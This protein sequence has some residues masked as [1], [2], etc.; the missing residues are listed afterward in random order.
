[1]G[2]LLAWPRLRAKGTTLVDMLEYVG[3]PNGMSLQEVS[4]SRTAHEMAKG[5]CEGTL[6]KA[7]PF[8]VEQTCIE[9]VA[10]R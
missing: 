4:W 10:L 8:A 5:W 1:M 3:S 2:K 7:R 6:K 9:Q